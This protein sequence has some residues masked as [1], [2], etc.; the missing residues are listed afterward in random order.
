MSMSVI[1]Y[2]ISVLLMTLLPHSVQY[3]WVT[4]VNKCVKNINPFIT[5]KSF[6][7]MLY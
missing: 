6:N 4:N 2:L 3:F 1:N 5:S 7:I